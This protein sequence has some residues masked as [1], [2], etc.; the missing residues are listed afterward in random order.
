MIG[1]GE[2]EVEGRQLGNA[3]E[4]FMKRA[5]LPAIVASTLWFSSMRKM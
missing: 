1:E 3:H 4:W 5:M 2:G